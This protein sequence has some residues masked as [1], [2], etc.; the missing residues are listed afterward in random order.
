[1]RMTGASLASSRNCWTSSKSRS[2]SPPASSAICDNETGPSPYCLSIAASISEIT[3]TCATI[4][5]ANAR[6][7]ASTV[8]VSDGSPI[9]TTT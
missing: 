4:G 3:P 9:A 5:R 2:F 7:R 6:R 8:Y 1:M